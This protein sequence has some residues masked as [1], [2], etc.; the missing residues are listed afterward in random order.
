[1]AAQAMGF[2][3]RLAA[4]RLRCCVGAIKD[5]LHSGDSLGMAQSRKQY[6]RSNEKR[7]SSVH[8]PLTKRAETSYKKFRPARFGEKAL[9]DLRRYRI[10]AHGPGDG[11]DGDSFFLHQL[12]N[13]SHGI[14][15]IDSGL[16][17]YRN[18]F[19]PVQRQ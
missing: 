1:M 2:V 4:L 16:H 13:Q 3:T 12:R 8:D 14:S 19:C 18:T 11:R 15:M 9:F 6:R 10:A 5:S 17:A 7:K